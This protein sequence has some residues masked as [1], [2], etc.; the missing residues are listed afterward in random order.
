MVRERFGGKCLMGGHP[1]L[2][3]RAAFVLLNTARTMLCRQGIAHCNGEGPWGGVGGG[4]GS[5]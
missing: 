5:F 1:L 4:C 2:G 3:A